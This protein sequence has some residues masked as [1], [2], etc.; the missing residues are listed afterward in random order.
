MYDIVVD[1]WYYL[2]CGK[3]NGNVWNSGIW[4]ITVNTESVIESSLWQ[5][6]KQIFVW[7]EINNKRAW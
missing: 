1:E 6:I 7:S 2:M 4:C 3:W 5:Q